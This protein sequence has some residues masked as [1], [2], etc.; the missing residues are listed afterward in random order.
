MNNLFDAER[1]ITPRTAVCVVD[2]KANRQS[3]PCALDENQAE[4]RTQAYLR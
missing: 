3:L 2:Y 4:A 1:T